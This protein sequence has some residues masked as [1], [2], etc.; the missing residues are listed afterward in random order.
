MQEAV[1]HD[2]LRATS[3]HDSTSLDNTCW[4]AIAGTWHEQVQLGHVGCQNPHLPVA[5]KYMWLKKKKL[6]SLWTQFPAD[7][8]HLRHFHQNYFGYHSKKCI[9]LYS[10]YVVNK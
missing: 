8:L 2:R 3:I 9:K 7:F 10:V 1:A 5:K 4:R 6:D